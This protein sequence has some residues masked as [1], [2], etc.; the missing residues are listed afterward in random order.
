MKSQE[1]THHEAWLNEKKKQER[2][3]NRHERKW[4]ENLLNRKWKWKMYEWKFLFL[5]FGGC[6]YSLQGGKKT[7][8][9]ILK[10]RQ[11]HAKINCSRG[12]FHFILLH[13]IKRK[14]PK[15]NFF[16]Y[17]QFLFLFSIRENKY[18]YAYVSSPMLQK[19]SQ[20]IHNVAMVT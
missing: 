18:L 15:N 11:A 19:K 13:K 10:M 4:R 1:K 2:Q 20:Q 8:Q 16:P 12:Y 14:V 17:I 3:T 7:Q 5:T 6:C 9:N